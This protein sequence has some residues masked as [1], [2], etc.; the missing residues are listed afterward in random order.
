MPQSSPLL[1]A[2]QKP[3][4]F[5]K[6]NA[7]ADHPNTH[8][9][10]KPQHQ[11]GE[12]ISPFSWEVLETD[13]DREEAKEVTNRI[14]DLLFRM[15]KHIVEVGLELARMKEKIPGHFTSWVE[16]IVGISDRTARYYMRIAHVFGSRPEIISGLPQTALIALAATNV[17]DK[18][19][20]DILSRYEAGK[21]TPKEVAAEVKKLVS[22]P[23]NHSVRDTTN[24]V[25]VNAEEAVA[26][27]TECEAGT[28]DAI[29]DVH[30]RDNGSELKAVVEERA[31]QGGG[32]LLSA[33]ERLA[34]L[35]FSSFE[36]ETMCE[37]GDLLLESSAPKLYEALRNVVFS[38]I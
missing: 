34:K 35:L 31:A 25:E 20:N 21:L 28:S 23:H 2:S 37:I 33:E 26:K 29:N 24:S 5:A 14:R 11:K 30:R 4:P 19:R 1:P 32:P 3:T 8:D 12:I 9:I 7:H 13:A 36:R 6:S 15:S 22:R 16:D 38:R 17:D 18:I 27:I 10:S